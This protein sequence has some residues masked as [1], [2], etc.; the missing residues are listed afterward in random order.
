MYI[1]KPDFN[2]EDFKLRAPKY[3]QDYLR[4]LDGEYENFLNEEIGVLSDSAFE[5]YSRSGNRIEYEKLYFR[6]RAMLRDFA[7][8]AW[9]GCAEAQH[10]LNEVMLKIC[11]ERTWAIPA[12][13]N[14]DDPYTV[15]DLFAAETGH[16]LT[17]I[18]ALIGSKIP[19]ETALMCVEETRRRVLDPFMKNATPYGWESSK[20]NWAAVCG[21]C[22]G[23]IAIYLL[24]DDEHLHSVTDRIKNAMDSYISGFSDDGACLEGLYYWNY[25]MTYFTAFLDLYRQRVGREFPTNREKVK[26]IADFGA[27]CCLSHGCTI[28]F[29]DG[30]ERGEIYCGLSSYLNAEYGAKRAAA[31]YT[32]S[33][34]GDG[35]GR[36]CRAS[37]DI[38]WAREPNGEEYR[39]N[40]IFP[41][42]QW[43]ILRRGDFCVVLKG[44]TNGEPHNHN[45]VGGVTVIKNGDVVL[46]DIGA[47]EYTARYFSDERYDILCN[48]SMGHSVPI[49]DGREQKAGEEFHASSFSAGENFA[50]SDISGAYD[51]EKLEK[52]VRR[53]EI[54]DSSVIIRDT[55]SLRAETEITERFVTRLDARER[56]GEV[57]MSRGVART[58]SLKSECGTLGV[59]RF[60]HRSHDGETEVICAA[61]FTFTARGEYVFTAEI[62]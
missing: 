30:F 8:K 4:E 51:C 1:F 62:K 50:L 36:W 33:F 40:D 19:K 17:E 54:T 15:I 6:R 56:N 48:R 55:F 16:A 12:H 13:I 34:S 43:A 42:A 14:G 32:A 9:L 3:A 35:C 38:A 23:M 41:D 47:G 46:C 44:G 59:R 58:A 37:R 22:V 26:K 29:S 7:L 28:S 21:G 11:A 18:I 31:E 24:E 10:R 60:D 39:G 49:V 2:C 53:I 52:C 61:D 45:D 57:Y 5:E 20:S 27:R 25:G